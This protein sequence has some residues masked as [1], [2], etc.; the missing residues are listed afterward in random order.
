MIIRFINNNRFLAKKVIEKLNGFLGVM[1]DVGQDFKDIVNEEYYE[2]LSSKK[3][4]VLEVGASNRP[5]FIN[6][7]SFKYYVMDIDHVVLEN[8]KFDYAIHQSVE[9][10]IDQKFDFIFSNYVLEHVRNN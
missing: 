10:S 9:N 8:N 1:P 7:N 4:K 5:Y 6:N 2:I 3:Q